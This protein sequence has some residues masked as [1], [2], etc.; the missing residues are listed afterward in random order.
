MSERVRI[1]DLGAGAPVAHVFLLQNVVLAKA[2]SGKS[3]M[4]LTLADRDGTYQGKLWDQADLIY[5]QLEKLTPVEIDGVIS[6]Y[7]EQNQVTVRTI[8]TLPW[9]DELFE[10]LV[11]T[12]KFSLSSLTEQLDAVLARITDPG[13]AAL[14]GV[15]RH[16]EELMQTFCQVPAAKFIHHN[17]HMIPTLSKLIE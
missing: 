9:S 12:S 5:E 15:L 2:K 13:L 6:V 14:V 3:Y 1:A 8:R 4:T 17:G 11:P 16:D 10:R 7:R